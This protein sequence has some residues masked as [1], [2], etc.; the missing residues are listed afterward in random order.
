MKEWGFDPKQLNS[1]CWELE[2]PEIFFNDKGEPKSSAGFDCILGNPP[3]EN[4]KT[5][6][7]EFF[8]SVDPEWPNGKNN[9]LEQTKRRSLLL[10]DASIK[11]LYAAYLLRTESFIKFLEVTN[12]Y[13][14]LSPS[15][16]SLTVRKIDEN[17][18]KLAA[19]SYVNKVNQEGTFGYLIPSGFAGDLGSRDL[20]RYY[21]QH[22]LLNFVIEFNEVNDVFPDATQS[23]MILIGSKMKTPEKFIY[24]QNQ[25]THRDLIRLECKPP[26]GLSYD[27]LDRMKLESQPFISAQTNIEESILRK[28]FQFSSPVETESPWKITAS[29]E[30]DTTDD[31]YLTK[32]VSASTYQVAKGENISRFGSPKTSEY[33]LNYK[34]FCK[35][36]PSLVK[37]IE[38]DRVAWRGVAGANNP[39]RMTAAV[40][41]PKFACFNSLRVVGELPTRNH[42]YYVSGILNSFV[43]EYF[44]RLQSKNNNVNTYLILVSPF[45][46][47]DVTDP[48]F[49]HIA[50]I[51]SRLHKNTLS[52][53][54]RENL[55][56]EIEAEIANVYGLSEEEFEFILE[57]FDKV[58][59][60]H[61]KVVLEKFSFRSSKKAAA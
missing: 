20:R 1:F 6:D 59:Q 56:A 17:T 37:R 25:K 16:E 51:S 4:I 50:D 23:F 28:V 45:P 21:L 9:K 46:R 10:R 33:K 48:K 15:F 49:K 41:P 27:L 30:L 11:E 39:R 55:E 44:I 24:V 7:A 3:W 26:N 22:R 31:M 29:R 52:Q 60:K 53:A 18:Y 38:T 40:I 43:Y 14:L 5:S 61:R 47:L 57:T 35:D 32:G 2:F 13:K 8:E 19:E 54:S 58:P 34:L 12:Q 42:S 36:K